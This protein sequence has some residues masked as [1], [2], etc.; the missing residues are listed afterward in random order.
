MYSSLLP[1]HQNT[2]SFNS[3]WS[4]KVLGGNYKF[5]YIKY[6]IKVI[7]NKISSF[8]RLCQLNK[9]LPDI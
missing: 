6:M 1:D 5:N 4:A 9:Y 8:T 7:H 3:F 2:N